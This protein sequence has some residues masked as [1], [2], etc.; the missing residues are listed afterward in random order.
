MTTHE[1]A[2]MLLSLP[3]NELLGQI[4][5]ELSD[6]RLAKMKYPYPFV[7]INGEL[8]LGDTSYSDGITNLHINIHEKSLNELLN[9]RERSENKTEANNLKRNLPD[10]SGKRVQCD[11]FPMFNGYEVVETVRNAN[12]SDINSN[13]WI[14]RLKGINQ[15]V[16]LY[17]Y[18]MV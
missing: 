2:Q 16:Q 18:E 7:Y 3:N 1:L 9:N 8:E 10:F 13:M 12:P 6:E 14:V 15:L 5:V 4:V 17:E 11:D